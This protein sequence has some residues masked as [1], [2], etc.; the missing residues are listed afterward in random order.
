MR[1]KLTKYFNLYSFKRIIPG[2]LFLI[3]SSVYAEVS[4]GDK[5]ITTPKFLLQTTH[6]QNITHM[7]FSP[8]GKYLISVSE[9]ATFNVMSVKGKLINTVKAHTQKINYISF[10]PDGKTFATAS[11]DSTAKVWDISSI[12]SLE[13][14]NPLFTLEHKLFVNQIVYSPDGMTLATA[15][16]DGT[17]KIWSNDGKLL[18]TLNGHSDK[19]SEGK[20]S[21][22]GK[23]IATI[24]QDSTTRIWTRSGE[25]VAELKDNFLQDF[26]PD[27]NLFITSASK[28]KVKLWNISLTNEIKE[29]IELT[30]DNNYINFVK[31]L[32][33]SKII[34][35]ASDSKIIK[36]NYKG[37][38]IGE[39]TGRL[40]DISPDGNKIITIQDDRVQIRNSEG[41]ILHELHF[42]NYLGNVVFTKDGKL[43]AI[44]QGFST[45]SHGIYVIN[46]EGQVVSGLYDITEPIDHILISPD[47]KIYVQ[48]TN[49]D[50]YYYPPGDLAIIRTIDGKFLKPFEWRYYGKE[51]F[52]DSKSLMVV[53]SRGEKKILNINGESMEYG[54]AEFTNIEFQNISPNGNMIAG[55]SKD[56]S[57]KIFDREGKL[58]FEIPEQKKIWK[59]A[60]SP[61]EKFLATTYDDNKTL[62]WN[63]KTRKIMTTLENTESYYGASF[64]SNGKLV[65][66]RNRKNYNTQIWNKK[67]K[68]LYSVD[69]QFYNLSP[70]GK[71]IITMDLDNLIRVW[72][73][74]PESKFKLV[75][76][77]KGNGRYTYINKLKFSPNG[78]L[79]IA[80]GNDGNVLVWDLEG[81]LLHRLE[82]HAGNI[83]SFTFINNGKILVTSAKDN[84]IKFWDYEN[85]KLLMTQIFQI[86]SSCITYTPNG[87][88]DFMKEDDLKY[89]S[90]RS[91]ESESGFL[92][93]KEIMKYHVPNLAKKILFE[94]FR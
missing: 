25:L 65:I 26:S 48:Q 13:K 71:K 34:I 54:K 63:L 14:V 31:F 9:D 77:L 40:D 76:E 49:Y 27:G 28:G 66:T 83:N 45:L 67:G 17:A 62:I 44:S 50:D 68:L 51:F 80:G 20:Y 21:P 29:Y 93:E 37:E 89:I 82:D 3:S 75:A 72:E 91:N 15:S 59:I 88:F 10:S 11:N 57:I 90:I 69:G 38:K 73:L 32:S 78:K 94:K 23:L 6:T 86:G 46:L 24:S 39:I 35:T 5:H 79:V 42:G 2:F 70:D 16:D 4:A 12:T 74:L 58:L 64:S 8:D 41:K 85:G 87:Y 1:V 60:F 36:W 19:I 56:K 22:D 30:H 53:T 47:E 92:S 18:Y 61:N 33:N 43:F 84:S 55:F 81:N 52:P 7:A